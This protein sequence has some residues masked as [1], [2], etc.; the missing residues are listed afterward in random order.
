MNEGQWNGVERDK[1]KAKEWRLLSRE[2][3]EREL[4]RFALDYLEE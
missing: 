1:D 4:L 3:Q 2:Q